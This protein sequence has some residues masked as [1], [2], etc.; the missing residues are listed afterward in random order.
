VGS[1][2][3]S[4]DAMSIEWIKMRKGLLGDPRVVRIMSALEADRFRTIGALFSAWCLLDEQTT[5]GM[6]HGYT[7]EAFDEIVGVHGLAAAM[8]D[9]GWL[10]IG[11]ADGVKFVAAPRFL[12]HNG[13]TAKRRA[14]DSVRKMSARAADICPESIPNPSA[15]TEDKTGTIEKEKEKEK[16]NTKIERAPN[17]DAVKKYWE[18]K[19]LTGDP[20]AFFDHYSANGWVQGR[21]KPVKDWKACVR[22]WEARD[23]ESPQ[24]KNGSIPRPSQN[25]SGFRSYLKQYNITGKLGED[26]ENL[27]QRL[28]RESRS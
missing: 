18:E 26:D 13:H 23:K 14:Q 21:G 22:T 2:F 12:E 3:F 17:F 15:H 7:P 16:D 1:G 6:L 28:L 27:Y 8:H 5:D 10:D 25:F 19:K 11:D 9:V 4:D 24:K 20:E